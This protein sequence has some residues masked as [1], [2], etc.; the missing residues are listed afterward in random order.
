M[1]P[2]LY[3]KPEGYVRR[4]IEGWNSRFRAA[5]TPNAD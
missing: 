3:G 5:H 2:H 1:V 4:Q